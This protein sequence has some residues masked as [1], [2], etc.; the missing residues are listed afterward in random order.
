MRYCIIFGITFILALI[1]IFYNP[2]LAVYKDSIT[3]Y[4]DNYE[5]GYLWNYSIDND[6]LKLIES[7]NNKWVFKPNK[8][9]KVK[10]TYYYKSD[11]ENKYTIYYEFK[12]KGN[13]IFWTKGEAKG[14]LSYPN[15]I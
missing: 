3:I 2:Y 15:P 8:N 14:L 6:N 11:N 12:V 10:L 4:Y 1:I 7:S 13:K 9:G 5:E